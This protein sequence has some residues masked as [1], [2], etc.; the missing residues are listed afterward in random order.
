MRFIFKYLLAEFF[1]ALANSAG[2]AAGPVVV[3]AIKKRFKVKRKP[4]KRKR[5]KVKL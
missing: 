4:V 5:K 2:D 1:L 3:K